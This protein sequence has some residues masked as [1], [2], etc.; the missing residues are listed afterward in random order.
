M[1]TVVSPPRVRIRLPWL[2]ITISV[3]VLVAAGVFLYR[4]VNRLSDL[5]LRRQQEDL[6]ASVVNLQREFSA[7]LHEAVW[8]FH[9]IPEPRSRTPAAVYS[10]LYSQWKNTARWP[11]LIDH[12]S[13]AF[14]SPS[15]RIVLAQL[16]P[17]SGSF[18]GEPWP[19]SLD[20][21]RNTLRRAIPGGA[22]R[23]EPVLHALNH[24]LM[25]RGFLL[26]GGATLALPILGF[27]SG[28]FGAPVLSRPPP[29][30]RRGDPN[31]EVIPPP[32]GPGL[33][34][35]SPLQRSAF[36]YVERRLE[37]SRL[38]GWCF[39]EFN[40]RFI[41]RQLLPFLVHQYFGP[42]GLAKYHV[43]VI[44]GNPQ[45]IIYASDP[46]VTL[47]SISACD[48]RIALFTPRA[49]SEP[50]AGARLAHWNH[51]LGAESS[52]LITPPSPTRPEENPDP[53]P[54][55]WQLLA[56][57]RLGSVAGEVA[58][59]RR[60]NLTVGFGG[61]LLLACSIGAIVIGMYRA[62]ALATRQMEFVAGI[63]HEL[64]TPLA[65]IESA[66]FN[67][68]RGKV[69]NPHRIQQYGEAIQTEGRR[70]SDLVEQTLAY[71][72][73]Q[74]GKQRYEFKPTRIL[75][76]VDEAL[77]EYDPL[78]NKMGWKVEKVIESSLPPV[79]ADPSVL[80]GVIKNLVGN[81]LKYASEGK[82]LRVTARA[83][84]TWRGTEVQVAIA[85]RGPGIDSKDLPHIFEPFYRGHRVVASPVPGAG[86]GLSLVSRHMQAHSGRVS[87]RT[88]NG[89]G[90]E[91][92]LHL[93]CL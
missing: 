50:A 70:L 5:D 2:A 28:D 13:I 45:H 16:E 80:K 73:V 55:S 81:A 57:D 4:W 65:V 75:Q 23:N 21:F 90:A 47:K 15:G 7:S 40:V 25:K 19:A 49:R 85:D 37:N 14:R 31:S 72:G 48:A 42:S 51:A 58:S 35:V 9:P 71:S 18:K 56:K 77:A 17:K 93:P 68:A 33:P 59:V 34:T 62:H 66:A 26:N 22:F 82:W 11:Q 78:F 79:S 10:E 39:L 3:V 61:L 24:V 43:A 32:N 36:L 46:S 1:G 69:E 6:N 38:I 87:V 52:N 74:A 83:V 76:V 44:T 84:D 30:F 88:N 53:D 27:A 67:L 64:R 41:R 8:F 60:R 12:L 54:E 20:T 91:F 92:A 86:L 29:P 63:S 89:S